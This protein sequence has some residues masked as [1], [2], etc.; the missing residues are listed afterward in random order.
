MQMLVIE[1][2]ALVRRHVQRTAQSLLVL[3]AAAVLAACGGGGGDGTAQGL[4]TDADTAPAGQGTPAQKG[5]TSPP[6]A[7]AQALV[8]LQ[9]GQVPAAT[10]VRA[11]AAPLPSLP[12]QGPG[13]G[14][15]SYTQAELFTPISWIRRDEQGTPAT[16]PGRKAFG[17]NVGIM[18][19][20]SLYRLQATKLGKLILTK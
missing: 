16:Y 9:P 11:R 19:N 12:V 5:A 10:P 1:L 15:L 18:H 4:A 8:T 17:L 20:G 6:D 3:L 2:A 13:M 14:N 7:Q